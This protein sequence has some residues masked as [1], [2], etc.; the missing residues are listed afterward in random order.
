MK[1]IKMSEPGWEKYFSSE[2]ELKKELFSH[3]CT[4][5]RV[6]YEDGEDWIDPPVSLESDLGDMLATPC[7]CEFNVE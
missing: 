4:A 1:L 5:C 2:K 7:G 6:G 3:I